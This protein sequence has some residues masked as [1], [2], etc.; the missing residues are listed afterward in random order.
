MRTMG[1]GGRREGCPVCDPRWNPQLAATGGHGGLHAMDAAER[2]MPAMEFPAW[3]RR[4]DLVCIA[5]SLPLLIPVLLLII[6]W[7]KLVSKGPALLRQQRIGR[8]G[9]PFILYKFRSMEMNVGTSRHEA[10]VRHLVTTDRPMIKLDLI[11]DSRVIA[12][13]CLLR[14]AGLDELPQ[15]LNVLRGE[16]S[17]VG[18][19]PCL[20]CEYAYFSPRQRERFNALPGLTGIW[21]VKGKNQATFR[22]MNLMDIHYVRHASLQLDLQ[23]MMKTPAALL[24]QML[25]AFQQKRSVMRRIG[26]PEPGLPAQDYTLSRHG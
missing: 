23:L 10:Y 16:M 18:P 19:R 11:C 9:K 21:Q 14:A 4:L 1:C 24:D 12:G 2:E 6:L 5:L 25:L 26:M 8:D 7:I 3:K 22:E 13:G 17:L 20:P 15:L